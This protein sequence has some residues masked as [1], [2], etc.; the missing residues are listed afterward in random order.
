MGVRDLVAAALMECLMTQGVLS[1]VPF[2]FVHAWLFRSQSQRT[3][4]GVTPGRVGV[5]RARVVRDFDGRLG[6]VAEDIRPFPP[7]ASPS[8]VVS[9]LA[10]SSARVASPIF[11]RVRLAASGARARRSRTIFAVRL[12]SRDGCTTAC[13][14]HL[15]DHGATEAF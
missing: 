10:A 1:G 6:C 14:L 13:A 11:V 12:T 8:L 2:P 3:V 9:L 15:Y 7:S 5:C 4:G